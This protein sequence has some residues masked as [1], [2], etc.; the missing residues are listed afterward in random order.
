MIALICSSYRELLHFSREGVGHYLVWLISGTIC[1]PSG[2][3]ALETVKVNRGNPGENQENPEGHTDSLR[4]SCRPA[5]P[6]PSSFLLSMPLIGSQ[7]GRKLERLPPE[8]TLLPPAGPSSRWVGRLNLWVHV[9][10]WLD[11]IQKDGIVFASGMHCASRNAWHL[12]I[13]DFIEVLFL[14]TLHYRQV[15]NC[16][17]FLVPV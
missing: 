11:P 14:H 16:W 1:E 6:T 15:Y 7:R 17:V 4:T 9:C 10:E 3:S 2:L 13:Q 5:H 12:V 8:V